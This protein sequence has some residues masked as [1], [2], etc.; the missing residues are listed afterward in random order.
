MSERQRGDRPQADRRDDDLREA[1]DTLRAETRAA[2]P[3]FATMM[4]RV[5]DEADA[6]P[7]LR[8]ESG[9]ADRAEPRAR[10]RFLRLGGWASVAAAAAIAAVLLTRG[11]TDADADFERLVATYATEVAPAATR[12]PTSG[13]LDVPGIALTRSVPSFGGALGGLGLPTPPEN[14]E[15]GRQS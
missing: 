13:L 4:A 7:P 2:A 12:S 11:G 6:M 9:G 15:E 14:P 3:D 5:R 8:V 10:P 1:F